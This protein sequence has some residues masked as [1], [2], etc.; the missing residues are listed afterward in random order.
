MIIYRLNKHVYLGSHLFLFNIWSV[1][2]KIVNLAENGRTGLCFLR[3]EDNIGKNKTVP[4]LFHA[5]RQIPWVYLEQVS[6]NGEWS[7]ARRLLPF[8]RSASP[9]GKE[10]TWDAYQQENSG[11]SQGLHGGLRKRSQVSEKPGAGAVNPCLFIC[12][13]A[14]AHGWN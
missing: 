7:G 10:K 11:H 4:Y 13:G 12:C 5:F 6:N 1:Q 2:I 14:K 8:L 3:H 9:C